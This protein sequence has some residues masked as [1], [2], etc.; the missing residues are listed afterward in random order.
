MWIYY[1]GKELSGYVQ[2]KGV[3]HGG[4]LAEVNDDYKAFVDWSLKLL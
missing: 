1:R 3:V 4:Y 2:T